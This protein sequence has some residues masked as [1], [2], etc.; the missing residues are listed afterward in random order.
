VSG[1]G[2]GVC[3]VAARGRGLGPGCRDVRALLSDDANREAALRVYAGRAGWGAAVYAQIAA[4]LAALVTGVIL[5]RRRLAG[6]P[7]GAAAW[8]AG[9][10][11]VAAIAMG[12]VGN[13]YSPGL[14]RLVEIYV[15]CDCADID[16]VLRVVIGL[17]AATAVFFAVVAGAI[18]WPAPLAPRTL[19]WTM[20]ALRATLYVGTLV[21]M[22][23]LGQTKALLVWTASFI[24]PGTLVE[25]SALLVAHETFSASVLLSWGLHYSLLLAAVYVPAAVILWHR[26]WHLAEEALPEDTVPEQEEWLRLQGLVTVPVQQIPRWIAILAP[27][28]LG[29]AAAL[30]DLVAP[31]G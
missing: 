23:A 5:L 24:P 13:R 30:L 27:A 11:I 22:A 31:A 17:A 7:R 26:A 15:T 16:G 8:A 3:G 29:S 18:V 19:A 28:I 10:A 12:Q 14:Q 9:T 25:P 2:D 4:C 1:G 20:R 21:L 6:G